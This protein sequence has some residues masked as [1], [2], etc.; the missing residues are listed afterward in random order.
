[1]LQG[2]EQL[3]IDSSGEE[4]KWRGKGSKLK[5]DGLYGG[6]TEEALDYLIGSMVVDTRILVLLVS[7]IG[8]S[9]LTIHDRNPDWPYLPPMRDTA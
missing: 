2:K 1:M 7:P 8:E 4:M 3:R 9:Y 6:R 5:V